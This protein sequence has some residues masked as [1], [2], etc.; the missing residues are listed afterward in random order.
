MKDQHAVLKMDVTRIRI[1]PL[2]TPNIEVM[3]AILD[4]K[5]GKLEKVI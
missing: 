5:N 1:Y 4:V 3:G 2:L